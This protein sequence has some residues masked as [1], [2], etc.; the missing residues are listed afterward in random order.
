M[1][2]EKR[3]DGTS[4]IF[5]MYEKSSLEIVI[6]FCI[7]ILSLCFLYSYKIT[8]SFLSMV[9]RDPLMCFSS[10]AT[11]LLSAGN[12]MGLAERAVSMVGKAHAKIVTKG[13]ATLSFEAL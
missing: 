7:Y 5:T 13:Q 10:F 3:E 4:F 12:E 1:L 2:R 11:R 6:S 8:R 9:K